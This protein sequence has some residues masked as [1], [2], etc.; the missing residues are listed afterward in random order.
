[1]NCPSCFGNY[2]REFFI[3]NNFCLA[4]LLLESRK[5][6][7]TNID[8]KS[9]AQGFY[10]CWINDSYLENKPQESMSPKEER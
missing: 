6:M 2:A 9:Y 3:S 1:M 10:D 8:K 7:Y 5:E 4:C